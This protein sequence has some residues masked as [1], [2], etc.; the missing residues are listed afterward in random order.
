MR[1]PGSTRYMTHS[2]R[3]KK[4]VK[5]LTYNGRTMSIAQWAPEVGLTY[6][7]IYQ[8]LKIG[9]SVQRA[10]TERKNVKA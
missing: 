2:M 9:W 5:T 10:L 6:D 4:P 1:K 3:T 8:R 7:C